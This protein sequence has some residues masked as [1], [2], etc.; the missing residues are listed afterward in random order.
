MPGNSRRPVALRSNVNESAR[1]Q[2]TAPRYNN[3]RS[4]PDMTAVHAPKACRLP[5][6]F[7]QENTEGSASVR[8]QC[9]SVR[10]E[11]WILRRIESAGT[12]EA[13]FD[14]WPNNIECS[15]VLVDSYW[16]SAL[17]LA[18]TLTL[19]LTLPLTSYQ[20]NFRFQSYEHY[21]SHPAPATKSPIEAWRLCHF[22]ENAR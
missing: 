15:S 8:C 11:V 18:L 1:Q 17:A 4:N 14:A 2:S 6:H 10:I 20:S 5:T 16:H 13:S 21:R 7:T 3:S 22:A 19:T 12:C 9:Q